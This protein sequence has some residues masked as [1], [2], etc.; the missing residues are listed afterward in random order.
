MEDFYEEF[1]DDSIQHD[2]RL[3]DFAEYFDN[4]NEDL[5]PDQQ[6]IEFWNQF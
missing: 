1:E 5:D 2:G 3:G 4:Y 6:D